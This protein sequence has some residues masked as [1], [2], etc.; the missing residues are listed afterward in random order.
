MLMEVAMD[1]EITLTTSAN[2][3][4]WTVTSVSEDGHRFLVAESDRACPS[5]AQ[6]AAEAEK[7][8][9]MAFNPNL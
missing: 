1:F 2:G 9:V 7:V 5:A 3:W 8:I 6:A 4:H